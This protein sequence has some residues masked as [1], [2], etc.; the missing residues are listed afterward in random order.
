MVNTRSVFPIRSPAA[1]SQPTSQRGLTCSRVGQ[2]EPGTSLHGRLFTPSSGFRD[3]AEG[4]RGSKLVPLLFLATWISFGDRGF[5]Q[6]LDDAAARAQLAEEINQKYGTHA[7][8]DLSF[9]ELSQLLGSLKVIYSIV[10]QD[11]AGLESQGYHDP[12]FDEIEARIV[13]A[14]RINQQY[15]T[16]LD[17]RQYDFV[18]LFLLEQ[19]FR[20]KSQ[21]AEPR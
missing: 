3:A 4:K 11:D 10:R 20:S 12:E 2:N 15:G 14:D 21:T 16:S 17:W 5:G 8:A 9:M 19:K 1:S 18:E 7:S 6:T 13:M